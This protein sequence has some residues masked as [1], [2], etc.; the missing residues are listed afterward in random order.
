MTG[1]FFNTTQVYMTES[2]SGNGQDLNFDASRANGLFGNSSTVQPLT[3]RF[4]PCV[5]V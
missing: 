1:A 2:H 4:L 3:M 5:K